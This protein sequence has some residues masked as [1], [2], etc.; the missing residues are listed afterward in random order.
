MGVL[1]SE[2]KEIETSTIEK[3][4]RFFFCKFFLFPVCFVELSGCLVVAVL[5]DFSLIPLFLF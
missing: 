3:I 2:T 5:L 4:L 1:W